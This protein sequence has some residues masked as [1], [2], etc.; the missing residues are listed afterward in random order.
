MQYKEENLKKNT[1]S[2]LWKFMNNRFVSFSAFFLVV[3]FL[4]FLPYYADGRS[5][6]C[7]GDASIQHY[8][9]LCYYGEYLRSIFRTLWNEHR[10]VIPAWDLGIGYG[11]DIITTLHYY[12]LGDPLTLISVFFSKEQTELCY[13]ILVILRLYLSGI[14]MLCYCKHRA[15]AAYS[16]VIGALIYSFS[17]YAISPAVF[18]P[19]FAIP[20]IYLPLLLLGADFLYEKKSPLLFMLSVAL[21]LLSNFYFFYMLVIMVVLYALLRYSCYYDKFRLVEFSRIFSRFL[22]CGMIGVLIAMPVFLPNLV[23]LLQSDRVSVAREIPLLY[24]TDYYRSLFEGI[25]SDFGQYYVYLSISAVAMVTVFAMLALPPKENLRLIIAVSVLFSFLLFPKVGSI[26][27][28]FN[29]VTNRWIWALVFALSYVTAKILPRTEELT[30]MQLVKLLLFSFVFYLLCY[31]PGQALSVQATFAIWILCLC[32]VLV[33]L[34]SAKVM[35]RKLF[36]ISIALLTMVTLAANGYFHASSEYGNWVGN[37]A[38]SGEAYS[39]YDQSIVKT[40]D[41]LPNEG[42]GRFDSANAVVDYNTA[43]LYDI[44]GTGFYFSTINPGTAEFQRS[45]MMNCAVDQQ[46]SGLD[47][48]SYLDAALSVAYFISDDSG[49]KRRPYGYDTPVAE[50]IYTSAHV[51]PL[52][53]AFDSVYTGG[54]TLSVTQKQQ[55]LLQRAMTDADFGLPDRIPEF[56][57]RGV[58]LRIS[59]AKDVTMH[60]NGFTVE[61]PGATVTFR[62]DGAENCEL[63][64][65]LEGLDYQSDNQASQA[66]ITVSCDD[67][68]KTLQYR[69]SYDN[70]ASD[71]HDFLINLGYAAEGRTEMTVSFNRAGEYQFTEFSVVEQPMEN[72]FDEIEGLANSGISNIL[73]DN[74]RILFSSDRTA[75]GIVCIAVPFQQGWSAAVNGEKA[76]VFCIQDGLCGVYLDA[77]EYDVVLAY[78]NPVRGISLFLCLAGVAAL[79]AVMF[80]YYRGRKGSALSCRSILPNVI[81]GTETVRLS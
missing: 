77:G 23:S 30:A 11:G 72:F 57:D 55:A 46:Y 21:A 1:D 26:F 79:I 37:S 65:I 68:T 76:D 28:G 60:D 2:I 53:Y 61:K 67:V 69:T 63:Y 6:I 15:V 25:I 5:L 45:Q 4:V 9:A 66:G 16:S 17:G 78:E 52:V 50:N 59:D 34:V 80:L 8:P 42:F 10:L 13:E 41:V 18:H 22:V 64:C 74:D 38:R 39:R 33:G 24:P 44:G 70:Y 36:R 12:C 81:A 71:R 32:V 73:V 54:D 62:F 31:L 75:P 14:V 35:P 48:R 19:F 40:V 29:Y 7:S 51:L 58:P 47:G 27:N 3:A 20:M 49:T 43:L 56:C